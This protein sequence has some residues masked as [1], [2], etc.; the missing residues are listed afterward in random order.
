MLQSRT[1]N[2]LPRAK[3][4]SQTDSRWLQLRFAPDKKWLDAC[5]N[6]RRHRSDHDYVGIFIACAQDIA[7]SVEKR[8]EI[9]PTQRQG[10]LYLRY[11][12]GQQIRQP[13]LKFLQTLAGTD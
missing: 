2:F 10:K 3:K 8:E 5:I 4:I 7:G 13:M 6:L 12:I 1:R 11:A 9:S